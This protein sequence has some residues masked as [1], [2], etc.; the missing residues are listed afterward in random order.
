MYC[1][2]LDHQSRTA[3]DPRT[4]DLPSMGALVGFYNACLG[5][6]VKQTWLKAINFTR[7]KIFTPKIN[8]IY[9]SNIRV[10]RN[11]KFVRFVCFFCFRQSKFIMCKLVVLTICNLL[12]M[13]VCRILYV[14]FTV[15]MNKNMLLI[16]KF[17]FS[18]NQFI[19][20][21]CNVLF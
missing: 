15:S 5:F 13:R 2:L 19:C 14:A 12:F 9:N 7:C 17:Q 11:N 4:M 20:T 3:F 18:T 16:D 10:L 6:L 8:R 1:R 21:R